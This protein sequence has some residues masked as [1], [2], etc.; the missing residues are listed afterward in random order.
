[1]A[2]EQRPP[3]LRRELIGALALVF[4]G[5][6]LVGALG[7]IVLVPRL[8]SPLEATVYL[9]LLLAGDV[10]IFALFGR[11]LLQRRVLEPLEKMITGAEAMATVDPSGRLPGGDTA[12]LARLAAAV[13]RM[14]E[15]LLAE[16]ER[17]GGNVR[18]LDE[19]NRMLVEA[20][21]ELVR[22]E[23]M[24]SVGRLAAGIAHEI[25][26]PLSAILG[27]LSL[28]QR[29]GERT[30]RLAARRQASR[31]LLL[32]A[33]SEARRIDRIVGSL[34]DY[35][36]A[37]EIKAQPIDVNE[38]IEQTLE[39]LS[40]Q[41]R[42]EGITVHREL[43]GPLPPVTADPYQLQQVL[44]NLLLNATDAVTPVSA[45]ELW[46]R[47]GRGERG[48]R[49]P[50]PSRRSD[51]PPHVDY[52]HRRRFQ[53][54]VRI[55]RPDPFPPGCEVVEILIADNGPGIPAELLDEIFEPFVTTKEPGKGTGLG[56]AVAA[57]LVDGMRGTI[58]AHSPPG[59]GASFTVVLPASPAEEQASFAG[60]PEP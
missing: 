51:D 56:L 42:L 18:S 10:A 41:G 14:A 39:L 54:P 20:R 33:E 38:V 59:G 11:H 5:A 2:A 6:L 17:L 48:M 52:S 40:T 24:A 1:M 58:R 57:R 26:N 36:R 43:G 15:R 21:D 29:E 31:E 23:K 30:S 12:E 27:Y 13:N 45:P 55:P 34:L 7:V 32:A 9:I 19:T 16:Q 25:G 50:L 49:F 35:S 46:L 37:R 22:A 60:N 53:R 4:A 8:R 28:L 47:S 3:T 44:V